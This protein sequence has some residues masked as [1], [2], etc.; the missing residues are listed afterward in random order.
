MSFLTVKL[1]L[2][3]VCS[4]VAVS[5]C[6]QLGSFHYSPAAKQV[7]YP[8]NSLR[9]FVFNAFLLF[10]LSSGHSVMPFCLVIYFCTYVCM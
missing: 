3:V 9:A 1:P 8:Q 5:K 2:S 10:I 6:L 7:H 4:S